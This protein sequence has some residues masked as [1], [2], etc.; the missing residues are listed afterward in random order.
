MFY[1]NGHYIRNITI[2]Q[3]MTPQ[4][5]VHPLRFENE[6]TKTLNRK[7]IYEKKNCF[8]LKNQWKKIAAKNQRGTQS[9]S[10]E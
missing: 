3:C 1:Q 7:R 4:L 5:D 2:L 9:F 6:K 10:A 8:K